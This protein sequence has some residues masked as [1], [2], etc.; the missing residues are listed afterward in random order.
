VRLALTHA[1]TWPE[2]RRGAERYI[3]EVSRALAARG[4][5]VT[6]ITSGWERPRFQV[7]DGVTIN[8]LPR[9]HRDQPA[10]ERSFGRRVAWPLLRGEFD[11]VHSLGP[12]DARA[13]VVAALVRRSRRTVYTNL[14]LP[15]RWAWDNR[16]DRKAHALVAK[17]ID[18]YGCMSQHALDALA[19]DY[20]RSGTLTPGGVDSDEFRPAGQR[21]PRPTVLFSGALDEPRKGTDA[22]LRAAASLI[23]SIPDLQVWLSGPGDPTPLLD[24][25][26]AALHGHVEVLP[27]GDPK[28]Q[29]E[30]YGR[31]WVT[32]L[33][34]KWDSFGMVVIEALACGTPVAVSNHSALPELVTPGVTG[35]LCDPDDDASVAD[36][37]AG[38]LA[39]APLPATV[40]ACRSSVMRFDWRTGIAPALERIYAGD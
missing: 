3:S 32:A 21:E 35:A 1:Y 36:A 38:A 16:P 8:S 30:R 23:P 15:F 29:A 14:G 20:G 4:H 19:Q 25:A 24:A 9:R 6:V 7:T 22:L 33:P 17:S 37:L 10:H 28:G 18:V 11:A 34:S 31:A 27:L 5:Q 12:P 26:P 2:V 39:L 13:S 40:E